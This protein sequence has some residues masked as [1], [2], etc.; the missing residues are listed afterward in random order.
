[1]AGPVLAPTPA[2]RH[3]AH[4][5]FATVAYA[6]QPPVGG[7]SFGS[8]G[9][10][11]AVRRAGER[12]SLQIHYEVLDPSHARRH[13][14]RT[15]FRDTL[16]ADLKAARGFGTTVEDQQRHA[17]G[18]A[19]EAAVAAGHA[20]V[21]YTIAAAT[22]VPSDW[23]DWGIEDAAAGI[24]NDAAD[25]DRSACCAWNSPR[26]PRSP[27]HACPSATASPVCRTGGGND[28]PAQ[29]QDVHAAAAECAGVA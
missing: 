7:T 26:T 6:V 13:V 11:L 27:R 29:Q 14:A 5:G 21:R 22:T 1:M 9:P 17:G 3:Y 23:A 12:R 10:L 24:E 16:V 8:L 15:R 2:A 19:H 18:H 4:D 25:R 20:L 28:D